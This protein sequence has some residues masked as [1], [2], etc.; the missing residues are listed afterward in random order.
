MI[1]RHRLLQSDS[2]FFVI[3][4]LCLVI[5]VSRD[6]YGSTFLLD[7]ESV[8]CAYYKISG[9][10]MQDQDIEELSASLG[11]PNFTAYK[12]SEIFTKNSIRTIR[13]RLMKKME[14]YGDNF[15]YKWMFTCTYDPDGNNSFPGCIL[16]PQPTPFIASRISRSGEILINKRLASIFEKLTPVAET[17]LR[18]TVYLK[19]QKIEY[20]YQHRHVARE[21]VTF[22]LR[23]VVFHP[24]KVEIHAENLPG[25]S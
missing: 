2:M 5:L 13:R 15:L 7:K 4:S 11:K 14:R 12:P 16:M 19:P 18:V 21:K 1:M 8:F 6:V 9:T 20:Q 22:P 17:E 24:V 10:F 3:L 25:Q 23:Y